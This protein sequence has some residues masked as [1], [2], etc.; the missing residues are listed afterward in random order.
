[1]NIDFIMLQET[2]STPNDERIWLSEWGGDGIFSHGRSNSKGVAILFARGLDISIK[3]VIRD[4]DGRFIILQ[5]LKEQEKITL[6]N[7]YAPT[8]NEASSQSLLI[9]KIHES[10]AELD[11]H[12]LYLGGDFNVKLDDTNSSSS[13]A[14]DSYIEQINILLNDYSLT[15]IWKRKNPTSQRGTFHRN[16]YSARLDYLFA[17]EYLL[18]SISSVQILPEPLSD[19]SMVFMAVKIPPTTR[20]PGY[21]RFDNGLL[22][23]S[24]F[25]EGMKTHIT[26]VLQQEEEIDSPNI[27]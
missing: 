4:P 20:G 23:D 6:V 14:R 25:T 10:L 15:D 7:I 21:W 11:I 8:S 9:G 17:P 19:H 1:M 27:R 2:H 16:T 12:T 22:K 24:T 26:Q 5:I 3:K 13:L 18:P